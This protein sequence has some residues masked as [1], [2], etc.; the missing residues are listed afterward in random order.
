MTDETPTNEMGNTLPM[1]TFIEDVSMSWEE[2]DDLI[3]DDTKRLVR[4]NWQKALEGLD[5]AGHTYMVRPLTMMP[6]YAS[7]RAAAILSD[8]ATIWLN[9]EWW[10]RKSEEELRHCA[11]FMGLSFV[12]D[13]INRGLAIENADHWRWSMAVNLVINRVLIDAG[14]GV[15]PDRGCFITSIN[16]QTTSEEV[17]ET[18]KGM[19]R[20]EICKAVWPL[21]WKG[22][23]LPEEQEAE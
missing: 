19:T 11:A 23:D 15:M 16:A 14:V 8:G 13:S 21:L 2:M 22:S 20:D 3:D 1:R 18:L 12:F 10:T 17:Y 5:K 6:I 4:T 7:E 9:P